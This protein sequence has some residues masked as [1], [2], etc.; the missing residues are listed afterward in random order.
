VST[1]VAQVNSEQADKKLDPY[2]NSDKGYPTLPKKKP[3][4]KHKDKTR[5]PK[6]CHGKGKGKGKGTGYVTSGPYPPTPTTFI[7]TTTSTT[8]TTVTTSPTGD[9]TPPVSNEGSPP[10]SDVGSPAPSDVGS[11]APSDGGSP[12]ASDEGSP[13]APSDEAAPPPT[14][15]EGSPPETSPAP[16]PDASTS[17]TLAGLCPT[18]CNPFDPAANKCDIT[19]SCATTGGNKYYCA[20]R[21]GFRYDNVNEADFGLQFKVDGQPYV[22]GTMNKSCNTPCKDLTCSEVPVRKQCA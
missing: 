18:V 22:Y 10:T 6:K 2:A 12:P 5:C 3:S 9:F 20:C 1:L 8:S 17:D 19:T 21:A 16:G 14:S 15:D 4:K 7:T 11:P 13:P